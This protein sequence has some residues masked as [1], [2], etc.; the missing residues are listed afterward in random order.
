MSDEHEED[1]MP[2]GE[3]WD[4]LDGG[5][6][7]CPECEEIPHDEDCVVG[8]IQKRMHP[9]L[10]KLLEACP[11]CGSKRT[12]AEWN[13]SQSQA[14]V[15]YECGM[16]FAWIFVG[17]GKDLKSHFSALGPNACARK[18]LEGVGHLMM[19]NGPE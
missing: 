18:I 16:G 8:W 3:L 15:E 17:E 2:L 4:Y 14:K 13:G 9:G 10:W 7:N 19:W 6:M 11:G 1:S 5:G 12:R